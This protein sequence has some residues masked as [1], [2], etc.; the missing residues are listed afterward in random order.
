MGLPWIKVDVN[1]PRHPKTLHLQS[2]LPP[3]QNAVALLVGFWGWIAEFYP[4]GL[5]P[6]FALLV[7][8]THLGIDLDPLIEARWLDKTD[9]GM[10]AHDWDFHNGPH[11]HAALMAAKRQQK[12]KAKKVKAKKRSGNAAPLPGGNAEKRSTV[13]KPLQD[14][15]EIR[16][17]VEEKLEAKDP[18]GATPAPGPAQPEPPAEERRVSS[19]AT[20]ALKRTLS[21]GAMQAEAP[22]AAIWES[23]S[24]AYRDKYGALPVRN[25]TV[26]AQLAQVIKRLGASEAPEVAAFY[27]G[28]RAAF[29]AQSMH[30][31]GLL[32]KDAEKLRTEWATGRQTTATEAKQREKTAANVTGWESLLRE[33]PKGVQNGVG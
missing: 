25:A 19:P 10:V 31:V 29:Y 26:S 9:A 3:G 4:E 33:K 16:V 14:V 30:P 11:A 5:V 22:T 17:D 27:V 28:H 23:Y 18:S 7:L 2:M 6:D 20:R 13:S 15:D 21:A 24:T 12:F 32:L 1:L 8:K